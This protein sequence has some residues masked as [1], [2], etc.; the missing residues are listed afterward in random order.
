MSAAWLQNT[1]EGLGKID[2]VMAKHLT[3][4]DNRSFGHMVIRPAA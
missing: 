2:T 1:M 3:S 4:W